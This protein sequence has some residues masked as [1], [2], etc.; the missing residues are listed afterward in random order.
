MTETMSSLKSE[1]KVFDKCRKKL[2][3]LQY[4]SNNLFLEQQDDFSDKTDSSNEIN[5]YS[6]EKAVQSLNESFQSEG[7]SPVRLKR[8]GETNYTTAKVS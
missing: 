2:Y 8:T 1:Y 6:R 7:K 3:Q 4:E 5:T